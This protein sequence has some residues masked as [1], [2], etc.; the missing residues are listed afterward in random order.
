MG[1]TQ[2]FSCIPYKIFDLP[3]KILNSLLQKQIQQFME[4]LLHILR[5]TKKV[6]QLMH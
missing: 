3:E 1:V 6:C 4:I 5:Q 2:S